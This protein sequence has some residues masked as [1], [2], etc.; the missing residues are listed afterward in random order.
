MPK[1]KKRIEISEQATPRPK[2]W[3]YQRP[4]YF[5]VESTNHLGTTKELGKFAFNDNQHK[6]YKSAYY[7]ALTAAQELLWK[8]RRR[9]NQ[10]LKNE[11]EKVAEITQG[12]KGS[13]HY[14]LQSWKA[15]AH[16]LRKKGWR[17]QEIAKILKSP[18]MRAAAR[19]SGKAEG[20]ATSADLL[21]YLQS[22]AF[23]ASLIKKDGADRCARW[24][25]TQPTFGFRK[26]WYPFLRLENKSSDLSLGPKAYYRDGTRR[27]V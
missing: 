20:K 17:I 26:W 14:S 24:W 19:H 7:E 23:R 11:A 18:I 4:G 3:K 5:L 2:S 16:L 21:R 25:S 15:C 12:V 9:P 1:I 8:T 6:G 22:G 27:E 13:Q 10:F